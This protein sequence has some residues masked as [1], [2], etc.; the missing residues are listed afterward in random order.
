MKQLIDIIDNI[1]DKYY[2]TKEIKD[3]DELKLILKNEIDNILFN[4]I[5]PILINKQ[6]LESVQNIISI[7]FW[8]DYYNEENEKP[9]R[10]LLLLN[11]H[12]SHE[13]IVSMFQ[14]LWNN[15][16]EN[17]S[18]LLKALENIPEYLQPDDFKYPYIRKIIYAIG[19]QPQPE[20]LLA[21]EKLASETDDEKI[22]ELAL[23]QLEKRKRLGRWEA[24]RKK[25]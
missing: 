8:F 2:T 16:T 10:E 11:F 6:N 9:M 24:E 18:V 1:F 21:L 12:N 13:D 20:S 3:D 4:K 7:G 23:H 22:K 15:N 19:A 14:S 25:S 5:L 17:I